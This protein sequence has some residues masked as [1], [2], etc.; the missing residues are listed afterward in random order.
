M[1][2]FPEKWIFESIVIGSYRPPAC[3]L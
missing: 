2:I 1:G 3:D